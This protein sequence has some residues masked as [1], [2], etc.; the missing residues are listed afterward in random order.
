M[1]VVES[2]HPSEY[3]STILSA[4]FQKA[5]TTQ[6]RHTFFNAFFYYVKKYNNK[7][8]ICKQIAAPLEANQGVVMWNQTPCKA[9]KTSLDAISQKALKAANG[10]IW[11]GKK[12]NWM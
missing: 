9:L 8:L 3:L 1:A 4:R 11:N 2:F 6:E 12:R 7:P 10:E 5:W